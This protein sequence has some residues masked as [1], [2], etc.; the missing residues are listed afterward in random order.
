MVHI[1]NTK[2]LSIANIYIHPR[3]STSAYYKTVDT[4]IQHIT[5]IP[6]SMNAQS[7]FW[8]SYTDD[9]RRQLIEDVISNSYHIILNTDTA[10]RVPNTTLQQTSSPD[11]TTESNTLN[12]RI[13]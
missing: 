5:S 11:I 8:H 9:H 10:T 7:T 13:S 4:D 3:D 1:N 12:N 6:H 2:Q